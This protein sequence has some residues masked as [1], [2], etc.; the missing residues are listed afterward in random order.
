MNLSSLSGL[1]RDQMTYKPPIPSR[2]TK[3]AIWR[4]AEEQRAKVKL[5]DG[6]QLSELVTKNKGAIS[7]IGILDSDQTDAIVVEP[8]GSFVIR[9]SSLTNA[10]RDNFTIAHELGHWLLHW[11]HVRK[12][13]P[14]GGMK[15]TRSVDKSNEALVRC[16]WE[17]NWFASAFLMPKEAFEVAYK[18]G[19]ASETFGVTQAAV[20]V[21]A[22]SL[23][24]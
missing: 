19:V 20:E 14:G 17:A 11:P 2:A 18:K 5:V 1:E 10:L 7:Y 6:F 4:F 13:F 22:R 12:Q 8:D 3:G 21:R 9:L 16:E 24:F 23:G 15:A